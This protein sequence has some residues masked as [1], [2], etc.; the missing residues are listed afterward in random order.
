MPREVWVLVAAGF[1]VA[2]GFGLVAPA[3][4]TFASSFGVSATAVSVVISAFAFTRL[5]FAPLGGRLLKVMSERPVYLAGLA[6]VALSSVGVAYSNTY[7]W[8]LITRGLGGIG[9]TLFTIS[10]FA[11]LVRVT[12][13]VLRGRAS[14]VYSSGFLIGTI[15]GPLFGGLLISFSIRAPFLAYAALLG[16]AIVVV[17]LLLGRG[18]LAPRQVSGKANEMTLRQALGNPTYRAALTSNFAVGWAVFGVRVAMLPLFVVQ[19]L[20]AETSMSGVALTVFAVGNAV[21]LP[22]AGKWAD[23]YGRRIGVLAGLVVSAAATAWIGISGSVWELLVACLVGGLGSGLITPG[24]QAAV[25]DVVGD[26]GAGPVLAVFQMAGDI[27]SVLGP[28]LAG[29]LVDHSGFGLAFGVTAVVVVLSTVPWFLAPETRTP[30]PR[31][32]RSGRIRAR[33]RK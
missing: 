16:V 26:K 8:L 19:I 1:I 33:V 24:Q 17:Q 20:A 7:T 29:V 28:I 21:V 10:S 30:Q 9:S 2:V 12:P 27:G 31:V 25:A 13:A 18:Q 23:Q 11:L 15:T 5:I 4:P 32:R 3:L 22:F 6:I 14:A